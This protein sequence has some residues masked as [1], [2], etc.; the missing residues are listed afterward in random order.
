MLVGATVL[1][2]TLRPGVLIG[3][4]HRSDSNPKTWGVDGLVPRFWIKP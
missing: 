4:C 3:W 1:N 2:Q